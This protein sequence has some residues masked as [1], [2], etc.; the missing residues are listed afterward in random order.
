[1]LNGTVSLKYRTGP[2]TTLRQLDFGKHYKKHYIRYQI[3][4]TSC[5]ACL[6]FDRPDIS[7]MPP[8]VRDLDIDDL[9]VVLIWWQIIR[10]SSFGATERY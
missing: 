1:M 9:C 5:S 10:S 4:L 7:C 3:I 6:V 2:D 8:S